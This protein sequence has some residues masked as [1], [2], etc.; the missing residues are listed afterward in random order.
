VKSDATVFVVDDDPDLLRSL[1]SLLESEGLEAETYSSAGDF[2]ASLP[3]A[4]PACILLDLR[5]PE[6][7]GLELQSTLAARGIDLPTIFLTA[8]GD[9]AACARAFKA[10]A[11]E[12]LE[13]PVHGAVLLKSVRRA[14][15]I[16]GLRWRF[17][18]PHAEIAARIQ[19]LSPREREVMGL[20][21]DGKSVKSI[22]A[23]LEISPQ[24]AA[25]H[26]ARMLQIMKVDCDAQLARL[27]DRF[28]E[29]QTPA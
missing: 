10:G 24:T 29:K 22:A 6:M 13:K 9:V 15:E 1:R 3:A 5:M 7:D 25:K 21:Y 19:Q 2:L 17:E 14:L 4:R 26:H 16:D 20:V 28:R 11:M 18:P 23:A 27:L 12:F 8:N